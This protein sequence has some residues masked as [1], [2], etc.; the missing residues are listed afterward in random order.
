MR[1]L[2]KFSLCCVLEEFEKS[3][4]DLS[5]HRA[6]RIPKTILVRFWVKMVEFW[7]YFQENFWSDSQ[8]NFRKFWS[9]LDN[10]YTGKV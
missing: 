7:S 9:D 2:R 6:H 10:I 4:K 8:S 3:T 5:I 1:L